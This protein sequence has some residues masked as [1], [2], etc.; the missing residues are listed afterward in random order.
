MFSCLVEVYLLS[1]NSGKLKPTIGIPNHENF[2]DYVDLSSKFGAVAQ[3][4]SF[5][6]S[7]WQCGP[8]TLPNEKVDDFIGSFF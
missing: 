6:T 7:N 1:S 3:E 4:S 5:Q 8:F 2:S